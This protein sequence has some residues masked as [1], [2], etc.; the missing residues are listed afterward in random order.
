MIS[1]GVSIE[2]KPQS[3]KN[4][5]SN[6]ITAVGKAVKKASS[7][8][9]GNLDY[10][11]MMN[12]P[13]L[14]VKITTPP[15]IAGEPT[16]L[17]AALANDFGFNLSNRWNNLVPISSLPFVGDIGQGVSGV[18]TAI[19]GATQLSI[20]SLWM[21]SAS[22]TGSEIPTFPVSLALLNYTANAHLISKFL[23]IAKGT[24]PPA[25]AYDASRAG[26]LEG[27]FE[28][29][30]EGQEWLGS[31]VD[32]VITTG[33]MF[34]TGDLFGDDKLTKEQWLSQHE[35]MQNLSDTI[36]HTTQWAVAAPCNYGLQPDRNESGAA[37]TPK[38]NTTFALQIGQWFSASKLLINSVNVRLSKE[39]APN[40]TPLVMYLDVV[41]RPYRSITFP[42]LSSYFKIK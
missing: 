3:A 11:K 2:G 33:G 31:T 17:T 19:G 23:A 35:F 10:V 9:A 41:F 42:E 38:P 8:S 29:I 21:T 5:A 24:L 13:Y 16:V 22:W 6:A 14:T 25:L 7:V 12:N 1:G 28:K 37:F 18:L 27:G 32:N 34:L 26:A 40:G 20:E 30:Q 39:I 4:I 36:S 15:S